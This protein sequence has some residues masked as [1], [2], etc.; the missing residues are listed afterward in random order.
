M[1]DI[2]EGSKLNK[3][4]IKELKE[5]LK[6]RKKGDYVEIVTSNVIEMMKDHSLLMKLYL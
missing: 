2:R 5:V 1:Y 6:D 3:T 4:Q